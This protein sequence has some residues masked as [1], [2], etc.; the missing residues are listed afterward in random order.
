MGRKRKS[1]DQIGTSGAPTASSS[2]AAGL[3][4]GGG[5]TAERI[6]ERAHEIYERRTAL[7]QPG[8]ADGDWLQAEA[9]LGSQ[10]AAKA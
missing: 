6:R 7:G 2:G 8:D 9:E 3:G 10:A 4:S 1:D 5:S